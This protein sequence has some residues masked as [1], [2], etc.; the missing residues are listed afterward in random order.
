MI[1]T[2]GSATAAPG[3]VLEL[4]DIDVE[5]HAAQMLARERIGQ[6]VLVDDLAARDIDQDAARLHHGKRSALNRWVVSG[7]HWQQTPQCRF[8]PGSRRGRPGPPIPLK[9]GGSGARR[10]APAGADDAHAE[11]G[12]EP[13]DLEARCRRRRPRTRSCPRAAAADRRDGRSRL[14]DPSPADGGPWRNAGC[15]PPRIPPWPACCRR[16]A[17][18]SRTSLPHRSPSSRLLAPA[19]RWWNHFSSAHGRA[20]RAGTASRP[21]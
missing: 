2:R 6:R 20:D 4:A 19:G 14:R 12:A 11:R 3:R 10:R 7:V 8:P 21:G 15:R 13:P 16:R 18:S 1:R 9:P 5:H 17:R